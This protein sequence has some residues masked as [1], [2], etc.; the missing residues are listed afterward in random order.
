[1]PLVFR[2]SYQELDKLT[3]GFA[4]CARSAQCASFKHHF[5]DCAERVQ[6]QQENPDHKGPKEDCVEECEFHRHLSCWKP[7]RGIPWGLVV[8]E[9]IMIV[10]LVFHLQHCATQCAAPKLWR[11]LK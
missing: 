7:K 9:L 6:E 8:T 11:L 3:T 1:M 10:D 2:L 5:D 4:E